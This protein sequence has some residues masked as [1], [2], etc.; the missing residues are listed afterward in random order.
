MSSEDAVSHSV[1]KYIVICVVLVVITAIEYFIFKIDSIRENAWIM[2]PGLG[3]LS[4]IKL[5]LVVSSYMHLESEPKA[6]KIIFITTALFSILIFIIY[7]LT[8]SGDIPPIVYG[9]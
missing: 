2:Y 8:A 9:K 3:L 6:L 5:V 4:F 7:F 1:R